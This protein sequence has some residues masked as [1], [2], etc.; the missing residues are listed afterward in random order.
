MAEDTKGTP[1]SKFATARAISP[2]GVSEVGQRNFVASPAA[3]HEGNHCN[4]P[5][6]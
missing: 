5:L 3:H 1:W 4:K 2:P 6:A